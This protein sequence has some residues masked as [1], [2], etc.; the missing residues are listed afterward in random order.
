MWVC[1]LYSW[2][3]QPLVYAQILRKQI[4]TKYPNQQLTCCSK[5][6][7]CKELVG[8]I[9]YIGPVAEGCVEGP[10]LRV[11]QVPDVT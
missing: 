9:A 1:L 2:K 8:G 4:T 7:P 11:E 10:S 3:S 6:L 5:P